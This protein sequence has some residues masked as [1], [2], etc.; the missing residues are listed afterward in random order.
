MAVKKGSRQGFWHKFWSAWWQRYPWKLDDNEEPPTNNPEKM[1]RLASVA[2]GED[3][4]KKE[5]E[6]QLMEVG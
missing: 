1:A 3:V 5:V 4:F 2:P 6:Q